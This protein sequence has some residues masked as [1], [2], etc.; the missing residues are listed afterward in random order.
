[1]IK[2]FRRVKD[3]KCIH[4]HGY[5]YGESLLSGVSN[6]NHCPHCLW[7]KHLDLDQAG[8]RL[9]ACKAG[10]QPVG[11]ALKRSRKKYSREQSGELMLIHHCTGCGSVSINRIA[12]DDDAERIYA[13]FD[14]SLRIDDNYR[15][16]L[17]ARGVLVLGAEDRSLVSRRL[18]GEIFDPILHLSPMHRL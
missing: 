11:L 18:F 13:L 15:A 12:A 16:G 17:A 2:D 10:M 7:S 8:D 3:F 4:C 5:V 14:D 1:M 6:R 9:S